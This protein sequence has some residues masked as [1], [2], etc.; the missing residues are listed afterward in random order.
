MMK[1]VCILGVLFGYAAF[2]SSNLFAADTL[3]NKVINSVKET[4][5]ARAKAFL[6]SNPVTVTDAYCE[7]SAGGRHDFYSEGDYWWPDPQKPDGPYIQK[8]GQT[9]PDNFTAHRLAMVRLS[10]TVATLT[11]AWL[12]TDDQISFTRSDGR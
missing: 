3:K 7:R 11:S 5:I 9:N 4:E 10:E 8:D 6:N 12:L 2:L 1:K